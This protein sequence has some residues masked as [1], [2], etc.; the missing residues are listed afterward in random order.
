MELEKLKAQAYDIFAQ[1]EFLQARLK[2][3][4]NLIANHKSEEKPEEITEE[5]KK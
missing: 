5:V 4:N 2:E 3:I 1:M